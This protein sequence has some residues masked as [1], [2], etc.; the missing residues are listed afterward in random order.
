MEKKGGLAFIYKNYRG[1]VIKAE[2]K[3]QSCSLALVAEALAIRE[4][5]CFD[6]NY[7]I[8]NAIIESDA[9]NVVQMLTIDIEEPDWE[10]TAV[11]DEIKIIKIKI[12]I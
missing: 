9:K 4:R 6:N 11:V 3:T 2:A 7:G 8:S 12:I 1:K 10:V 5:I